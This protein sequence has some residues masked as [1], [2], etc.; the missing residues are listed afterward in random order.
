MKKFLI[1]I[2]FFSNLS[3]A[4]PEQSSFDISERLS[5]RVDFWTKIYSYYTTSQGVFHLVDDPSFILGE[6]DI[7]S[8]N[9]NSILSSGEK[10]KRINKLIKSKRAEFIS[11]WKISDP[12]SVRLQMGLK[13]RMQ[14][15][16]FLSG[17]YLPMMES[18][19]KKN[20]LPP[21]LTRIVFV[22]SSFNVFAQSK[23]GASGLWQIM[24]SVAIFYCFIH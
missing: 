7:T 2:L 6:I 22:E 12:K 13:D 10:Q 21:E 20:D 18:I 3:W 16:L 24:P 1:L 4:L 15:A 19:F 5:E 14:K 11:K 8:I 23:V 17:R 9:T